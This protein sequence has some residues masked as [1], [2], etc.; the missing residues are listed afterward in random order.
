MWRRN[1]YQEFA[2]NTSLSEDELQELQPYLKAI[3][4]KPWQS[5]QNR[6]ECPFCSVKIASQ[7][8]SFADHWLHSSNCEPG[9]NN[10]HISNTQSFSV[11]WLF[12]E[13]G[14][15]SVGSL[16]RLSSWLSNNIVLA[17]LWRYTIKPLV[18][19]ILAIFGMLL[20]LLYLADGLG[21]EVIPMIFVDYGWLGF[22]IYPLAVYLDLRGREEMRKIRIRPK[23]VRIPGA[24][25]DL[26]TFVSRIAAVPILG[27]IVTFYFPVYLVSKIKY[28]K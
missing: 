27:P 9:T 8:E 3:D 13:G 26:V 21:S 23:D 11:K 14:I 17:F 5:H 25:T 22:F 6:V 16:V 15:R 19:P 18:F 20:Q 12:L 7:P 4:D 1:Q 2:Q 10:S 24:G 28:R